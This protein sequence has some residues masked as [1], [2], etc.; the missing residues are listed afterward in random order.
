VQRDPRTYLALRDSQEAEMETTMTIDTATANAALERAA[1]LS[2]LAPSIHNTQPWHWRIA[3][4]HADLHA[5]LARQLAVNDPDRRMLTI[6]CGGAL[7]HL[8]VGLDAAGCGY[9]VAVMPNPDDDTHLARVT[10]T[11]RQEVRPEAARR[12]QTAEI[13][14]TDRR[15]LLDQ[16]LPGSVLDMLRSEAARF[17]VGLDPLD[18][19]QTIALASA[20]ARAQHDQVTSP[21]SRAELDAWSGAGRPPFAGVPDPNILD[22]PPETTVPSRDFGHVG[23]LPVDDTHDAGATYAILYGMDDEPASWLQAGE[24]LSALWLAA[25]EHGVAVLPLSAAAEEPMTRGELR[26]ILAGVGYPYIAVRLGV[27]DD[28]QPM[29]PHTPR[30]KPDVTIEVLD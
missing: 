28:S 9:D 6:S 27:A 16:P 12:A 15:P 2:G 21:D 24:A 4:G 25:T 23:T 29:P 17:Q 14:Q 3:A 1:R 8:M 10:V 11:V 20:I 18:R 26:R 19:D 5:D 30:L 7:A 13:R 22:R